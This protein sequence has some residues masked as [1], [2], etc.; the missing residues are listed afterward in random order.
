MVIILYSAETGKS[1]IANMG[2]PEYSYYFVLKKFRDVLQKFAHIIEVKNPEIDVDFVYEKCRLRGEACLFFS[3]SPPHKTVTGL[4]CPTICVFAW[5]YTTIPT[6]IWSEN[7]RNDWRYVFRDHGC[8]IS[9]SSFAVRAVQK[10]MG[11]DFPI[12]SIPAPVWDDYVKFNGKKTS[13]RSNGFDLS[14]KGALIDFQG[15][16]TS[17]AVEENGKNFIEK[18]SSSDDEVD[19]YLNGVIY[20][21]VFNPNDGR[22]N[23]TDLIRGFIWAFR[24]VA[25]V[26]LVM[27]LVNYDYELI[28]PLVINEVKKMAPFK[29]RVIAVHGYLNDHEYARLTQ[30]ST[31]VV[32]TAFGEGQCLPLMEYMSAGKPAVAPAHTAMEDYINE[33]NTFVVKS[34]EERASWPHDPRSIFRTMRYRINWESLYHAYLESYAVA[35]NDPDRY[36]RMSRCAVESLQK[37]CSKAM[38]EERLKMVFQACGIPDDGG[39]A[40]TYWEAW[41]KAYRLRS[42]LQTIPAHL[43]SQIRPFLRRFL[44]E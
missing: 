24:E 43:F 44:K 41:Y 22:K 15:L 42:F 40:S 3:F 37:Y 39:K 28:R 7:P 31:Y 35:K 1:V 38:V 17:G 2:V 16:D 25:D 27:K 26:T 11:N 5:E 19:V 29:C 32:N 36:L 14:F 6:D 18:H 12:W 4:N 20:T 10:A 30:E 9:H 13:A 21:T 33:E 34:N 8:A 23:W